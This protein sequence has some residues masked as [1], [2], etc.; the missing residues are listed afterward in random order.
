MRFKKEIILLYSLSHQ[1]II[2]A[3]AA[4][5]DD[6]NMYLAMEYA[7][8]GELFDRIAPDIGIGEELAH[9]YFR[10]LAAGVVSSP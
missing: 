1:N 9:L 7:V 3:F 6:E 5:E 4:V 10:Q 8:S 2:Q